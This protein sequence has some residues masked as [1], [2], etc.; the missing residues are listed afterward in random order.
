M[1]NRT[2]Q[3]ANRKQPYKRKMTEKRRLQNRAAQKTL[4]EKRKNRVN[5]LERSIATSSSN[6]A[7]LTE[8][9]GDMSIEDDIA[10]KENALNIALTTNTDVAS[11]AV[12][13]DS[14]VS[15]LTGSKEGSL[16]EEGYNAE[17]QLAYA[18][19]KRL[20]L[21][22]VILAGIKALSSQES[23]SPTSDA[24][25]SRSASSRLSSPASEFFSFLPTPSTN[26]IFLRLQA[27]TEAY[28]E[29]ARTLGLALEEI[30]RPSCKSPF[31]DSYSSSI[32]LSHSNPIP[33]D[34]RPTPTQIQFK[35]HP[36]ID[37]IPF[38]WFRDRIIIFGAI[39]PPTFSPADLKRDI[40]GGGLLCWKSKGTSTGQPW[41]RRSWEAAPWFLTKWGWLIEEQGQVEEQSR[42]W[43]QLRGE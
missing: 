9:Y 6:E 11:S 16:A 36:F 33:I 8:E 18:K 12:T 7:S 24:R 34:L 29:N 5:L 31:I 14:D 38:P 35:H 4:R 37:L 22:T 2:D 17:E 21:R 15:T 1:D 28:Q 26:G 32:A 10:T 27:N 23:M 3:K 43:R 30:M 13:L 19:T 41:D 25:P 42:W 20:G 39:D 40:L